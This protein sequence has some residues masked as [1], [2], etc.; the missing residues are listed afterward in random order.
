M[1]EF[2][3]RNWD[4][5]PIGFF[6]AFFNPKYNAGYFFISDLQ[7]KFSFFSYTKEDGLNEETLSITKGTL[8]LF[9]RLAFDKLEGKNQYW[10]FTKKEEE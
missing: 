6:N 4:D 1:E 8:I 9:A 2:G 7:K 3:K 5:N 10:E